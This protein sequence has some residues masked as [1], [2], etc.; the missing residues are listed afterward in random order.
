[1]PTLD[2]HES[3]WVVMA[4][5][6]TMAGRPT[7]TFPSGVRLVHA[8]RT[9]GLYL[10]ETSLDEDGLRRALATLGMGDLVV[11]PQRTYTLAAHD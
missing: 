11:S 7:P 9:P 10:V 8:G 4:K 2:P 1:M 6:E 5:R 3:Q